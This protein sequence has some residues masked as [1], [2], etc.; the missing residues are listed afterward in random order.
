MAEL[1]QYAVDLVRTSQPSFLLL[2]LGNAAAGKDADFVA[3]FKDS[4]TDR[5]QRLPAVW[6]ARVYARDSVDV[7]WG[8]FPLVPMKYLSLVDLLGDG[9]EAAHS[10]I[11]FVQD[12]YAKEKS[13][14]DVATWLYYPVSERYGIARGNIPTAVMIHYTNPVAGKET[15]YAEWFN[16]RLLRHAAM[17]D[18]LVSGQRFERSLYQ[19][20]GALEPTYQTVALY[21][22]A[23]SSERLIEAFK[24]PPPDLPDMVSLDTG[25][26]TESAYL[27][28]V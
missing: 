25:R 26:F 19:K 8:R 6:R 11:D 22:Q 21:D 16:T 23:G 7:T 27:P 2:V 10:V 1:N 9:P 14:A 28:L 4:F 13:A 5:L 18:P 17:F 12:I 3:W 24:I 15:E 20:P